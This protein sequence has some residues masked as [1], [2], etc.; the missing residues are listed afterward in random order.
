MARSLSEKNACYKT[1]LHKYTHKYL[2]RQAPSCT[3]LEHNLIKVE[4]N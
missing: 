2:Q 4:R 3:L 1:M